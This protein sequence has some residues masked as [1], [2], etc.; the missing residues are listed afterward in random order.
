V[1]GKS[2]NKKDF[3]Q[4]NYDENA[5]PIDY[6]PQQEFNKN[7]QKNIFTTAQADYTHPFKKHGELEAGYKFTFRQLYSDFYADSL[8]NSENGMLK[9]FGNGMLKF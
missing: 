4:S 7:T 2:I 3:L 9:F 6:V 1:N 5:Y 8:Y